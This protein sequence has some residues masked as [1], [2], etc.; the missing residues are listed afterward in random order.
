MDVENKKLCL[1]GEEEDLSRMFDPPSRETEE[2]QKY[3]DDRRRSNH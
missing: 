1:P 3:P 2:E